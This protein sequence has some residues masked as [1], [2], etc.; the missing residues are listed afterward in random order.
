VGPSWLDWSCSC[1]SALYAAPGTVIRSLNSLTLCLLL[2]DEA[3][4]IHNGSIV[5]VEKEPVCD[6]SLH[7]TSR[8]VIGSTFVRHLMSSGRRFGPSPKKKEEKYRK[9]NNTTAAGLSTSAALG[10]T[11][12]ATNKSTSRSTDTHCLIHTCLVVAAAS[13]C[14][15]K[16]GNCIRCFRWYSRSGWTWPCSGGS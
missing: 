2:D 12:L 9:A 13:G 5:T 16:T 11:R 8:H 10:P 4:Q 14:T 6:R 3:Q 7:K 1:R 15:I